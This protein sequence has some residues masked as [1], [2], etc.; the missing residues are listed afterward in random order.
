MTSIQRA[1]RRIYGPFFVMAFTL[2]G[3]CNTDRGEAAPETASALDT[4]VRPAATEGW[5]AAGDS[6]PGTPWTRQDWD[7]FQAVIRQATDQA[8]DTLPLGD[9]IAR[10]GALFLG[11][12]YVPQTLEVPGPER[13]VINLRG[14]DCVTFVENVLALTRFQRVHGADLLGDPE[15]ARRHFEADLTA[16]RY[17][18]GRIDGYASRLHY[19]SEWMGEG[20][21]AGR[22]ELV[23]GTLGG[24]ADPEPLDFMSAHRG[25]YPQLADDTAYGA[26]QSV[27]AA[28]NASGPRTYLPENAMAAAAG[29]IRSGDVIAATSTLE[30]LDVAHTGIAWWV[31]GE[32]HLIHAPLVGS[33]VVLSDRTLVDRIVGIGTQDGIMVGRPTAAWLGGGR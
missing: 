25:A 26:I 12:P 11:T 8:L 20:A 32:L 27:E 22:L 4:P 3:A 23:S 14:L 24:V 19:F 10:M 31:E 18:G 30:G 29:G 1:A 2:V 9:A 17:R 21:S 5:P 6:I 28:L 16:L 15:A 13:L 7:I 33:T